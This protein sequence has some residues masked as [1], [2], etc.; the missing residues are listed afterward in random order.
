M[1]SFLFSR[2][3][4]MPYS[5]A[6]RGKMHIY[7]RSQRFHAETPTKSVNCQANRGRIAEGKKTAWRPRS[8]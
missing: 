7:W 8:T 1:H 5:L 3:K 2:T 4:S 6:E